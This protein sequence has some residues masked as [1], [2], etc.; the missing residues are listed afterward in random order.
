MS[1]V[2]VDAFWGVP[3]SSKSSKFEAGGA[4]VDDDPAGL[5]TSA[6]S[7]WTVR[8]AIGCDGSSKSPKSPKLDVEANVF[9]GACFGGGVGPDW[10]GVKADIDWRDGGEVAD[11][12][13]AIEAGAGRGDGAAIGEARLAIFGI[14]DGEA[15]AGVDAK[16]SSHIELV[17]VLLL[18]GGLFCTGGGVEVGESPKYKPPSRSISLDLAGGAILKLLELAVLDGPRGGGARAAGRA[19]GFEANIDSRPA[20]CSP[21]PACMLNK[22]PIPFSSSCCA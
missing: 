7:A 20:I 3:K 9:R 22:S 12:G 21:R 17:A 18:L 6:D 16:K 11:D 2:A 14:A 15:L 5:G 19:A 4:R 13:P 8:G 1:N 10:V